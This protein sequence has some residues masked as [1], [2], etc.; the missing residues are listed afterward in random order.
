MDA[1]LLCVCAPIGRAL[2]PFARCPPRPKKR[3]A[4]RRG[5]GHLRLASL[6]QGSY[7]L[8]QTNSHGACDGLCRKTRGVATIAEGYSRKQ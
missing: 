8:L 4:L 5:V 6:S 3:R 1:A 7:Q 2:I